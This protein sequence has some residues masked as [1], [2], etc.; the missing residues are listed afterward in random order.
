MHIAILAKKGRDRYLRAMSVILNRCTLPGQATLNIEDCAFRE[1]HAHW[2]GALCN[3]GGTVT[4]DYSDFIGNY[5]YDGGAT[6]NERRPTETTA[7]IG[8]VDYCTF[9]DNTA[10]SG[11]AFAAINMDRTEPG[12]VST[13]TNRDFQ[14]NVAGIGNAIC[15]QSPSV[16]NLDDV[17][18]GNT[19][20]ANQ[21]IV[22]S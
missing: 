5:A 8:I 15:I 13:I 17:N 21:N 3:Y 9:N 4:I 1:N 7:P 14:N 12:T 6:T 16:D 11:G 22:I 18:N 10:R 20:G 19:Y 2:G